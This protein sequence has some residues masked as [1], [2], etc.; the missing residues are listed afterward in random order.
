[1]NPHAV[2]R[3]DRLTLAAFLGI[4]LIGGNNFVA[5]RLSNQELAPFWGAALRFS[6]AAIILFALAAV[7]RLTVPKGRALVGCLMY[8]FLSFTGS[9]AFLYWGLQ[10]VSAG[11]GA[12]IV[13]LVPLLT[14]FLAVVHGLET[15]RWRGLM[16]ALI[17]LGGI[18]L[19]FGEQLGTSAS[20]AHILAIF[21]GAICI[22]ESNVAVKWFPKSHPV[23]TNA[24]AMG[25]GSVPLFLLSALAGER[26][27]LP[28][29]PAT[30]LALVYLVT[31]GSILMFVL[32]VFVITRWTAS[33]TGYSVVLFPIGAVGMA[34]A[35]SG[36]SVTPLF[37]AGAT[38]V[39]VGV[40]VG[41]LTRVDR[42]SP[43][44][45]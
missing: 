34:A 16:G 43:A 41:A 36:E 21:A 10:E 27:A 4:V 6:S 40:Y 28:T 8:G 9:Y 2:S 25:A 31:I 1:M 19:I 20:L 5:V 37:V 44:V 26:W 13:A 29:M 22:A 39:L 7:S 30:W 14:L 15:F 3:P 23:I 12:V 38:L 11:L 17:S 32:F 45:S 42:P 18:G 24:L 33:A 35:I